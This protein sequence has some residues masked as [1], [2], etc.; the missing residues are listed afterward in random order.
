MINIQVNLIF[1]ARLF[2]YLKIRIAPILRII[3]IKNRTAMKRLLLFVIMSLM[4]LFNLQ[5]LLA[6]EVASRTIS[7]SENDPSLGNAFIGLI[8]INEVTNQTGAVTVRAQSYSNCRFVNWTLN[9]EVVSTETSYVDTT[10]GDKHYVANFE[11]VPKYGISIISNNPAMG[12]VIEINRDLYEGEKITLL[13]FPNEG[14]E[15]VNW[16]VNGSIVSISP[17]YSITIQSE[18]EYVANFQVALNKIGIA[19]AESSLKQNGTSAVSNIKDGNYK[20][21]FYTENF[22]SAGSTVSVTLEKEAVI[23]RV[24]LYFATYHRP[25]AAKIQAS[26]DNKHWYDIEGANFNGSAAKYHQQKSS[27]LISKYT[28]EPVIA[29]YLRMY[30]TSPSY[31]A[32]EMM[33]FEAYEYLVDVAPRTI[34]VT[35]NDATMGTAYV[36]TEGTTEVT[37]QTEPL[38]LVAT[39]AN[40]SYKFVNWTVNG[41]VVST[42]AHYYDVT[43]GDKQYVANFTNAQIFD[44]KVSSADIKQ[45]YVTAT[46]TGNVYEGEEILFTA[47]AA[48]GCRFV[49][50]TID[51]EEVSNAN[52]YEFF[53]TEDVDL[54]A[55]FTDNY[56]QLTTVPTIYINTENGFGVTS[57]EDYVNAYVTVRGAENE[58]DN[59]TEVLT[60]IKGRGNST[61]GMAKKPYRLKFDEKIKF[62]GNEAKEKNWVLLAN[63]ADKTLMRNA[64]AFETARNMM[65][66]GFTP[67]VTFVDVVLNGENLGSYMLTD[68]VEVKPKRVPV[69]EQEATTTMSD[70]EITGGYLIEVDGFANSEISWFQTTQGM[71]VTI[72]Y[73][74]DDE[75]NADQY[76]Y[77]SNYTQSMENAMFSTNFT[78]AELGWRKYID[79]A[80]MVDWYIACELFGNS[81]SWWSTYIY[82]ERDDVFKFGPLW[83]FDIAFN[84]DDRLGDATTLMMRTNAHEPKTWISRWWQDAGFVSAVKARWE[85]LRQAG[86]KEFMINYINNTEEYLQT[87][88]QNNFNVWKILNTKVYRELEARGSYEAEVD[89]LR[90]YVTS[91]IAY[92]DEQFELSELTFSVVATPSDPEKGT[93]QVSVSQVVEGDSVI[94]TATPKA[95]YRFANWTLNGKLL[96]VE[97]PYKTLVTSNSN[98]IA[99]FVKSDEMIYGASLQ[100]KAFGIPASQLGFNNQT[101]F[102]IAFWIYFNEFNHEDGGTQLLNIRTPEDGWPASDWG[103]LWSTIAKGGNITDYGDRL[104]EGNLSLSCRTN[105]SAANVLTPPSYVTFEPQK[106]YHVAVVLGYT[107]NRTI[108]LYVNGKLIASENLRYEGMYS[109]KSSNVIMVGGPAF[110]RAAIDG[111]IDEV[112]LY[113]KAI[114]ADE[115]KAAMQH[116]N[117]VNDE[118]LIGYWDFEGNTVET[119][120]LYSIGSNNNLVACMYDVY[121]KTEGTNAYISKPFVFTE[122]YLGEEYDLYVTATPSDKKKGVVDVSANK[123]D[124]G[125]EV[126]LTA[127]PAEGY[128]FLNWT[129]KGEVVSTEAIYQPTITEHTDYVANF[130]E[131]SGVASTEV[132]ETIKV[133]VSGN[134]IKLF[135]T[136]AGEQVTLFTTSGVVIASAI[137]EDSVT[138]IPTTATGVIIVKVGERVLKVVK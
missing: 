131:A 133:A 52:P 99:N 113:K 55:N 101:P 119:N 24:D 134:G 31:D 14:Y 40:P 108:D 88:Q 3:T 61:W 118:T 105:S 12:S 111:I 125:E 8:E 79:E 45:G 116:Q 38:V 129:V 56:K 121:M 87:S 41:E 90:N 130:S 16:T 1:L 6:Q 112:R 109:W 66:F 11:E 110:A 104:K 76:T 36:E 37:S 62:L 136:T 123:V 93:V 81:D 25:Q 94:L 106:W 51:G 32:L 127:T 43:E 69:T 7:V 70:A 13:A 97:N 77:I 4:A 26:I 80:S 73:P 95:G 115:V 47:T 135:G 83:D 17:E 103:Y 53:I 9:G 89:F 22:V 91:R 74:K 15:F 85:E 138:I 75:I 19:D 59:I 84:N 44:V 67:S 27:Y 71:K 78:D 68:Q 2:L 42:D 50:W 96:S 86:V 122:G 132:A 107:S 92:L 29:K 23:G 100:G 60:E 117:N 114:T 72:K 98:Y 10:E 54:V 137:A 49:N 28:A 46:K 35:V 120:N 57:K 128:E 48:G 39:P 124:T 82:K 33:E 34:N 30:I 65:N 64:L 18:V 20:S 58:E 102:S 126:T 5:Q 21:H 63:Y